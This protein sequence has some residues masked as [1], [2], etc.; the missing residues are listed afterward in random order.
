M[1]V[2]RSLSFN[3][4]ISLGFTGHLRLEYVE[5]ETQCFTEEL[6]LSVGV[7]SVEVASAQRRCRFA[8]NVL[9]F[10]QSKSN[11]FITMSSRMPSEM[12]KGEEPYELRPGEVFFD[13]DAVRKR[14]KAMGYTS[15]HQLAED[16][17]STRPTLARDL[18]SP[19]IQAAKLN[20]IAKAL[21]TS[22][23][24]L[25]PMTTYERAQLV[26]SKIEPPYDWE[27]VEMVTGPVI[28]ANGISY[29]TAKLKSIPQTEG[30]ARGKLYDMLE[31]YGLD[32]ERL[33]E[34][35]TRHAKV[36]EKLRGS[37]F[38]ARHRTIFT[39]HEDTAWWVLDDWIEGQTLEERMD[40]EQSFSHQA[41][42]EIGL[43]ILFGLQEL[44]AQEIAARELAPERIYTSDDFTRI[45]LT[46][47]EMAKFLPDGSISVSGRWTQKMV[48]PYRA[49]EHIPDSEEART[50]TPGIKGDIFSWAA[51][52]IDLL[53]RNP[54][55][56]DDVL[57]VALLATLGD[58]P[59]SKFL[60]RCRSKRASVRPDNV[61]EVLE[62]WQ[63]WAEKQRIQ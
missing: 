43:Q 44:H 52:M 3:R 11:R 35:L 8:Q 47:F 9:N 28:A 54:G 33:H 60:M 58:A 40:A 6:L 10:C 61:S 32:R 19:A 16:C 7:S 48:N 56:E 22:P 30:L 2:S 41:I 5:K 36:C 13:A 38:L 49:P 23:S 1:V 46:D 63:P 45:T 29:C 39:F 25:Q 18:K 42:G 57:L 4:A 53:T 37:R 27:I 21:D 14:M 51:V 55:A 50:A 20:A 31:V 59:L 17:H 26:R 62:T 12:P 24:S 34:R 15:V